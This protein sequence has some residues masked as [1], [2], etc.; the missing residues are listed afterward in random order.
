M[1][2][3]LIGDIHFGTKS[4]STIWLDNQIKFFK[5]K[6]FKIIDEEKDLQRIVFLGDLFDIRYSINQQIGIEVKK[7]IRELCS[8]FQYP[9]EIIFVAGNHDYY[10]PLEEFVDYNAYELVFGPEFRKCYPNIRFVT[11]DPY[12]DSVDGSLFLPWYWTEN[13][14]HFDELLYQY[15]FGSEVKAVFC[16]A[17]LTIWPGGRIS[18]LKGIPVYSGHIHY[19]YDDEIGNLHNLGAAI[20]L[21]FGDVNQDRYL[22]ILE[23]L[24]ITKKI[25]NDITPKFLRIFNEDIFD[26]NEDIFDNSYVQICVSSQNINKAK[27]IDQIKYIRTTYTSSNI[28]IRV[29]EDNEVSPTFVAEGFNTNI[30]KYIESN[31]PKHLTDKYQMIKSKIDKED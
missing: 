26:I 30:N 18:S 21:N 16:H 28:S 3:L 20:P 13:P 11:K 27:Y 7:V 23:D 6:L 25:K 17:D 1:K 14:D 10:S 24:Q 2:Q 29:V 9:Y 4:N 19:L 15:K 22:Y 8:K 12:F 31:I 5:K